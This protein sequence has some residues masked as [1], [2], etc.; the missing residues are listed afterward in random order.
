MEIKRNILFYLGKEKGKQ[1][2]K[3]RMRIRWD[4]HMVNF[5]VGHRVII[6]KWVTDSQRCKKNTTNLKK[7]SASVINRDIQK[8]EDKADEVFKTFEV[9]NKIPTAEEYRNA[10]KE[11]TGRIKPT[12]P[13]DFFGY[14]DNFTHETG[15]L[16]SWTQATFNRFKSVK[17]HLE[18]FNPELT[19]EQLD[20]AGLTEY[21]I[22]LREVKDLRNVSIAKHVSLLKWFL[23]WTVK[24]KC[25]AE[26]AFLVF[27]PKLK[28]AE[29]KI[30]YLHW[31]ELMT[32]HKKEIPK[33]KETLSRV[34][35]AF[36]FCCFSSLRYSDVANLKRSDVYTNH[37]EITTIKTTDALKIELN[38]YSKE[39]L[40][41]YKDYESPDNKA[42][43]VISNQK[44]N[45]N[46]KIVAEMCKLTRPITMTYYK[47]NERFDDVHPLHKLIS[48][49]AGRRT[50]ISNALI[51]GIQ[52]EVV[53]K[54]TGHKDYK[55][56]KPYIDIADKEKEKSMK[57]FNK[58]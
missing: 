47:G 52:A 22:F 28:I 55:S 7:V 9:E 30:V 25:N 53:M 33:D 41:K 54:W 10:F 34:R 4:E 26:H 40:D 20:E 14:F 29:K 21:V 38:D 17:N 13:I 8:L 57:L 44:M 35:D 27:K 18:E 45:D 58:K 12:L 2:A 42:L 32:L 6:D 39:I 43:P 48:T 5:N 49:H 15:K 24:K 19:F 23:R 51:L 31:D 37:I 11:S 36:C 46:L 16:N 56:M 50:F 3:L 1:D